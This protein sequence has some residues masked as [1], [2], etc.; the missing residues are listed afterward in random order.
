[1]GKSTAMK[2]LV[3]SWANG[4][5]EEMKSFHFVFHI[6]LK[7]VKDDSPFENIIVAQYKGL[8]A[9]KVNPSEI[10]SVL[11]GDTKKQSATADRWT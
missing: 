7:H 3:I 8:K 11:D 5:S 9:N 1:M 10:R 2:H 4:T 6:S